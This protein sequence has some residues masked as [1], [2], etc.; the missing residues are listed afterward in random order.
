M[1]IFYNFLQEIPPIT[2][3]ILIIGV[4]LSVLVGFD[5]IPYTKLNLNWEEI[6]VNH[7]V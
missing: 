5:F 6:F 1:P 2:R 4:A 3:S 7:E